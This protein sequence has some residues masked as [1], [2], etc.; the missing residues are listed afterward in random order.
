MS[1]IPFDNSLWL[2]QVEGLRMSWWSLAIGLIGI[3]I[4]Y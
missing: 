4:V 3:A 1:G 2:P